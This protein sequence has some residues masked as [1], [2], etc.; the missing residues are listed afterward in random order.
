MMKKYS[1][2]VINPFAVAVGEKYD[3]KK[4]KDLLML[5]RDIPDIVFLVFHLQND[6]T[7]LCL[8]V[9]EEYSHKVD[10]IESFGTVLE[11][12]YQI[13]RIQSFVSLRLAKK[14]VYPLVNDDIESDI[15]SFLKDAPYGVFGIKLGHCSSKHILRQ[16]NS[17]LKKKDE[18]NK[19]IDPYEK[20]ARQKTES[21]VFFSSEIFF[22]TRQIFDVDVFRE[23]IPHTLQHE[24]NYLKEKNRVSLTAKNPDRAT[25]HLQK[26][27]SSKPHKSNNILSE[28]EV[29]QFVRFPKNSQ[30]L[31]LDTAKS[32]SM[33]TELH[34]ET[35]FDEAGM[36][37]D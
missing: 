6:G 5:C 3:E 2:Y 28:S 15:F 4:D 24:P 37:V 22:G 16:Y 25:K 36:E 35:P 34:D 12:A 9:P 17:L 33:S 13:T 18:N 20:L 21:T 31:R 10:S 29:L 14:P 11:P 26:I 32:P 27:L 8:R 23:M 30:N 7:V 1:W 19:C